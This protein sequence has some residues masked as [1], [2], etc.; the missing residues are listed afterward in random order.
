MCLDYS[1]PHKMEDDLNFL[2]KWKTTLNF[3]KMED[4]LNI[5]FPLYEIFIN[6]RSRGNRFWSLD[7]NLIIK[8]L[9]Q[10]SYHSLTL[11]IHARPASGRSFLKTF[12]SFKVNLNAFFLIK[13]INADANR[14]LHYER[15]L[16]CWD[17]ILFGW[18]ISI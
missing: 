9:Y 15:G 11:S 17:I 14:G 10:I 6:C 7:D 13:R 16:K 2:Q 3:W 18:G 12:S 4:N 5:S 1:R 8:L